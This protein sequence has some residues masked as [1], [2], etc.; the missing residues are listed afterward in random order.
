MDN[1][2]Q[3]QNLRELQKSEINKLKRDYNKLRHFLAITS[4]PPC[5]LLFR[6]YVCALV[7]EDVD[8]CVVHKGT[9]IGDLDFTKTFLVP[10]QDGGYNPNRRDNWINVK[11]AAIVDGDYRVFEIITEEK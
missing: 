1:Y 8:I 9:Q 4:A 11:S 6:A 3:W 5:H 10:L 7:T 2:K